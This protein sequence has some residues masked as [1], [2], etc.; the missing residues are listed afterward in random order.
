[1][2]KDLPSKAL[3][4]RSFTSHGASWGFIESPRTCFCFVSRIL[5]EVHKYFQ[6]PFTRAHLKSGWKKGLPATFWLEGLSFPGCSLVFFCFEKLFLIGG[7][8]KMVGRSPAQPP[9]HFKMSSAFIPVSLK[10]DP[11]REFQG[12]QGRAN[13]KARKTWQK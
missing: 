5:K 13:R 2:H 7:P 1:M 9:N 8:L 3:R 6:K 12:A 11:L 4:R 10:V